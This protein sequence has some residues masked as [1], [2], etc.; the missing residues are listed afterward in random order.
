MVVVSC[1]SSIT[2]LRMATEKKRPKKGKEDEEL[3][4]FPRAGLEARSGDLVP[5]GGVM[6]K[7]RISSAFLKRCSDD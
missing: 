5:L 7:V 6:L 1:L 2:S 4:A 3:R